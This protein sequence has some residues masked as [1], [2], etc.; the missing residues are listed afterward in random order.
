[1][2]TEDKSQM[3]LFSPEDEKEAQ[4]VLDRLHKHEWNTQSKSQADRL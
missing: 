4:K 2:T 3:P 1:M